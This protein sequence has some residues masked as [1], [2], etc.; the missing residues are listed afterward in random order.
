MVRLFPANLVSIPLQAIRDP[1]N[2]YSDL[3]EL[4][5][6]SNTTPAKAL[7]LVPSP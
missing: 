4:V 1:Y 2:P 3:S 7:Q 6:L 5:R